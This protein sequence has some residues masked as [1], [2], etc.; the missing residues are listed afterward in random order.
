MIRLVLLRLLESYFRRWYI[1]PLPIFLLIAASLF[2]TMRTKTTYIAVGALYVQGQSLLTSLTAIQNTGYAWITPAQATVDEIRELLQADAFV[3]AIIQQTDLEAS[4]GQGDDAALRV[5]NSKR[6]EMWAQ[7]LGSNLIQIGAVDEQGALAE[8]MAKALVE[9]YVQWKISADQ[10]ES[11][12]AQTFFEDLTQTYQADLDMAQQELQTYLSDHPDPTRGERPTEEKMQIDQ[13]QATASEANSRL[14]G[15]LD[16]L[17]SAKLAQA[18]AESK[19]RQAYQVVDTPH[20]PA[21]AGTSKK[22]LLMN[23]VIMAVVG[24]ILGVI[25]AAGAALLDTSYRFPIDVQNGLNLP[26]LAVVPDAAGRGKSGSAKGGRKG[27]EAKK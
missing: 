22:K 1:Y 17:N 19:A 7:P 6:G 15:A 9:A 5:I 8:Q 21:T 14:A 20:V 25:G 10:Q 16:K 13:L 12:S 26:T 23:M 27:R 11:T 4:M 3:R 24:L 18:Q 2:S